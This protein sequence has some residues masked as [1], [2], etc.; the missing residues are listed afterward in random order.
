MA[1]AMMLMTGMSS[2]QSRLNKSMSYGAG[3]RV[4]LGSMMQKSEGEASDRTK[5]FDGAVEGVFTYYF[6]QH[7]TKL[8]LFGF[9]TG[10]S[11]GFRQNS[12]TMDNIDLTY[13]AA[14]AQGNSITY[15]ATAEDVKETDLQLALELPVMFS[16][17]YNRIFGNLGLRMGIPVMSRYKQVMSNPTLTATYDEFDVTIYGERVTGRV[18]SDDNKK[19]A[20]LD[21]SSFN[22][23]LSFEAGYTFNVLGNKLQA[24]MYLDYGLVDNFKGKGDNFTD[25]DP[26]AID[27]ASSTP[28][29][30]IVHSLTD[31][32]VSNVGIFCMGIRGVYVWSYPK[33]QGSSSSSSRKGRS[34]VRRGGTRW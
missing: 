18:S 20:K 17:Y 24:G 11:L 14:D 34:K 33:Q 26:A 8:P 15:H 12:L 7:K 6:P 21:A 25:A 31:S 13:Q 9:R 23:C 32:Y 16:A 5:G 2:A 4:G 3:L 1:I 27:G 10:L 28:A 19:K 22:L 30:V 29:T